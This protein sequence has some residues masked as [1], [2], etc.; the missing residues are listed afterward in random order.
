MTLLDHLC[1]SIEERKRAGTAFER[2]LPEAL[3]ELAPDGFQ[4][5]ELETMMLLQ[6]NLPIMKKFLYL[7]GLVTTMTLTLGMTFRLLHW[8]GGSEL[9]NFGFL[10]FT[11]IFL[12]AVGFN[13]YRKKVTRS[14]YEKLRL[15]AG[16][17]SA[18]VT[19]S[20]VLLKVLALP[21]DILLLVGAGIFTFAFL[22]LLF[23][24]MYKKSL[25]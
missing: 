19:G 1:T 5:I 18:V 16:E 6:S 20:A 14:S 4:K 15:F 13:N 2:A 8:P 22:P 17:A 21:G 23:F 10:G 24:T 9:F 11:L 7:S 3:E 25:A 12:P